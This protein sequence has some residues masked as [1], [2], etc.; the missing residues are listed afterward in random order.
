MLRVV[1]VEG[2]HKRAE[3]GAEQRRAGPVHERSAHARRRRLRCPTRSHQ[4]GA[5]NRRQRNVQ[6]EDETP[7]S[8]HRG[9]RGQRRAV[10]GTQHAPGFLQPG[11]RPERK[12]A[13]ALAIEIRGQRERDR[14]EPAAAE[15]LHETSGD[16]PRQTGKHP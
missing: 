10:N 4:A 9:G 11:H 6:P 1:G 14:D 2:E 15:A 7:A 5:A 13:R 12:S 8:G 3:A 16:E